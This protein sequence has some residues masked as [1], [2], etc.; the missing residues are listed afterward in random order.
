MRSL[1]VLPD[2]R[3]RSC[4]VSSMLE[5]YAAGAYA[6]EKYSS[7]LGDGKPCSGEAPRVLPGMLVPIWRVWLAGMLGTLGMMLGAPLMLDE[8]KLCEWAWL[9]GRDANDGAK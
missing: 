5:L 2:E 3:G 6:D 8:H 7:M 9:D 1:L 4:V